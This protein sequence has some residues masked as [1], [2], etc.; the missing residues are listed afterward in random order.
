MTLYI[1]LCGFVFTTS[2][3]SRMSRQRHTRRYRR[4]ENKRQIRETAEVEKITMTNDK[5]P[6]LRVYSPLS[7]LFPHKMDKFA[8]SGA[9]KL[10]QIKA[11]TVYVAH[12]TT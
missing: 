8:T 5:L 10:S 3:A 7:G 12:S 11:F 1:M 6:W 2:I 4:G 9:I